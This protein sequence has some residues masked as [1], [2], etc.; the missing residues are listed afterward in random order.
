MAVA[1]LESVVAGLTVT[2]GLSG[3]QSYTS[4]TL[5][6][7]SGVPAPISGTPN[8]TASAA[9]QAL[10]TPA[11]PTYSHPTSFGQRDFPMR[12]SSFSPDEANGMLKYLNIPPGSGHTPPSTNLL[13]SRSISTSHFPPESSGARGSSGTA[14]SLK[15]SSYTFKTRDAVSM[16]DRALSSLAGPVG[17]TIILPPL[18]RTT[19]YADPSSLRQGARGASEPRSSPDDSTVA[20]RTEDKKQSRPSTFGRRFWRRRRGQLIHH[21]TSRRIFDII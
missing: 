13:P 18:S 12:E 6:D 19:S 7:T 1:R 21:T 10:Y 17:E 16:K 9:P 11:N 5:R 3:D 14:R 8:V 15:D 4:N 2:P 20:P